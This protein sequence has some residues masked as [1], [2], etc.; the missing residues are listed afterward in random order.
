M[1]AAAVLAASTMAV[2]ASGCTSPSSQAVGVDSDRH[3]EIRLAEANGEAGS[4]AIEIAG[5]PA[6]DLAA[7]RAASL[8]PDEWAALLRVTVDGRANEPGDR[9]AVLGAYA[10]DDAAIRF[11]PLYGLDPG[12][13]YKVVFTPSLLP[14][15]ADAGKA[16]W[17]SRQIETIVRTPAVERQPTTRI[18]RTY[19]TAEVIPENQLRMY[20][21][22]SAPMGFRSGAEHVRLLDAAGALVEGAF[23]PLDLGLWNA[24]RTRYTLLFDPGRVKSGILPNETL[25]KAIASGRSY[26]L[27][28]DAAWRDAQGQPLAEPFRRRFRVGAAV[29]AAI[30]PS[31]WRVTAPAAFTTHPLRVAFPRPL[32]YA[33]LKRALVV[34]SLGSEGRD[35]GGDRGTESSRR[36]TDPGIVERAVAG[37]IAVGNAETEWLFTPETSWQAGEYGL[38]VLPVLEDPAGNRV[39]RP[40]E[41]PTAEATA[42]GRTGSTR[43]V[44]FTIDEP[45]RA[46]H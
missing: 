22:F 41:V 15:R 33:L 46:R 18:V 10:V 11:A 31:A 43:I 3:P 13:P 16:A 35:P 24:D 7:L 6:A 12:L 26:T 37:R 2:A 8:T 17:R 36:D 14:G 30:D 21:E 27:E 23:L 45:P 25:G 5:L 38:A 19:P 29:E 42:E 34:V 39:G 20:V 40:F 32:D 1:R 4:S 9:P 28:I 44:P